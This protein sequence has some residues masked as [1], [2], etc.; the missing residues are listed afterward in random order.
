MRL[1]SRYRSDGEADVS[2]EQ[3]LRTSADRRTLLTGQREVLTPR[4]EDGYSRRED[5]P[6][7]SPPTGQATA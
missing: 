7:T 6:L 5:R 4:L 1:A 3:P 2:A